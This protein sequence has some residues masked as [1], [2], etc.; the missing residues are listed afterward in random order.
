MPSHSE[1]ISAQLYG[2]MPFYRVL[3]E[4]YNKLH[5]DEQSDGRSAQNVDSIDWMFDADQ[6]L[7]PHDLARRF[8]TASTVE[9]R[10]NSEDVAVTVLHKD[11]GAFAIALSAYSRADGIVDESKLDDFKKALS[12]L[13][14]E[15]LEVAKFREQRCVKTLPLS[16]YAAKLRDGEVKVGPQNLLESNRLFLEAAFPTQLMRTRDRRLS[17]TYGKIRTH[18]HTALCLSGGGIRSAT[19]AL[20][21]VQALAEKKSLAKFDYISTVSGGGFLGGWLSAWMKQAGAKNVE[22]ALRRTPTAKLDPEPVPVRHLRAYTNYLSPKIGLLSA[23]TWTL[24]ATYIRN[25][26]LNWLVIIPFI[27]AVLLVPWTAVAIMNSKPEEW[28]WLGDV[29]YPFSMLSHWDWL[30]TTVQSWSGFKTHQL[31]VWGYA[32]G[33][34]AGA[35]AVRYVHRDEPK[36]RKGSKRPT[37]GK[38]QAQFL[39]RCLMPLVLCSI[40]LTTAFSL[41]WSWDFTKGTTLP[42][43]LWKYFAGFGI[44]IH[45]VGWLCAI[46]SSWKRFAVGMIVI[47][48]SAGLIGAISGWVAPMMVRSPKFYVTFAMPIYLCLLMLSGQIYLGLVSRGTTDSDREWGARFD[49]WIFIVVVAWAAISAIVLWGPDVF[50]FGYRLLIGGSLGGISGIITL[51][52]GSSAKTDGKAANAAS[53]STVSTAK[54]LTRKLADVALGLAAPLF[55]VALIILIS[56]LDIWLLDRMCAIRNAAC[57]DFPNINSVLDVAIDIRPWAVMLVMIAVAI[58]GVITGMTIDTNEFS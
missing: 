23:D 55:A 36:A 29:V 5:P 1:D 34:L 6:I 28:P 7:D 37:Q 15:M 30:G 19:F 40:L 14:N 9:G 33:F 58:L 38:T 48:I 12:E 45:L 47:V 26:L 25:V 2:P 43:N 56:T 52:L 10:R 31:V 24:V 42:D 18:K 54:S 4:E 8:K 53:G 20:G 44:A 57:N 21:V 49:A 32:I 46:P 39:V 22:D 16:P 27:A 41:S 17:K 51:V 35:I 3:D 11:K 13:L 50:S